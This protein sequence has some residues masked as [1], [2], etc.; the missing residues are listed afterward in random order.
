[1]KNP[2]TSAAELRLLLS[3]HITIIFLAKTRSGLSMPKGAGTHLVR[4]A[5][6]KSF[7]VFSSMNA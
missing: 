3:R 2:V 6:Y 5:V 1:M 4:S 7:M